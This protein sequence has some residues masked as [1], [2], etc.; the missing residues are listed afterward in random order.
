MANK[1]ILHTKD[2]TPDDDILIGLVSEEPPYKAA[3]ILS[4][5]LAKNFLVNTHY[6]SE[7]FPKTSEEE[8]PQ[9]SINFEFF[10]WKS[11][12]KGKTIFLI[13]NRQ[14]IEISDQQK[15][16]HS[17]YDNQDIVSTKAFVL[18]PAWKS[19]DYILRFDGFEHE[20]IEEIAD[21]IKKSKL[22]RMVV[23]NQTKNIE[24]AVTLY[25]FD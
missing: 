5:L 11:E 19:I 25:F 7:K 24:N 10:R 22:F 4:K 1:N 18:V 9:K 14:N 8:L 17:L 21:K 12:S 3:Y 6:T 15:N 20:A 16:T 23:V 2:Y 13:P